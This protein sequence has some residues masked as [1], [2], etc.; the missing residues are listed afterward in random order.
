M[1]IGFIGLGIMGESMCENIVMKHNDTVF[2]NDHKQSQI[3]KLVSLGAVGCDS[4]IDIAKNADVIITMIPTSKHVEDCYTEILPYLKKGKICIDMST[5]EPS[6]SV[7]VANMVKETGASFA[8]CP[9]VRS[10]VDAIAG[11]LGVLVGCEEELYPIIEPI[12]A[13][14]GS[15]IIYMGKNGMGLTAKICHNT[16]VAQ[17]QNGVNETLVLAQKLGISIDN[18][19][20]AVAAGG[21]QNFYLNAQRDKLKNEDWTTAFSLENVCKDINICAAMSEEIG[22]EMPGMLAAKAA[23]EKAM[24][25][26]WGKQDFRQTYRIVRG[27][28]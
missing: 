7:K 13:Y 16:L 27:D 8:D 18:F 10:K 24:E 4:N 19:A 1:K 25:K 26:G 9:V 6:V 3:N 5:I 23:I 17:I 15:K 28:E 2:A 21:A 22:F 12:L 20:D 14:M 11:T